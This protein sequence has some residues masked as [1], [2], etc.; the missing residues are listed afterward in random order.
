MIF[1]KERWR[2]LLFMIFLSVKR[3]SDM[4]KKRKQSDM[5]MDAGTPEMARHFNIVPRLS[6]PTTTTMKVLDGNEIDRL[7]LVDAIN[8]SQHATL[9]TLANKLLACGFSALRSP[10][11]SSPI[12]SDPSV[13]ADKKANTIRGAVSIIKRMDNHSL[14]GKYRRKQTVNLV[15]QDAPWKGQM[16]ELHAIIR[17]LEEILIG[18]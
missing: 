10:D 6:S 18:R 7:L 13:V 17:A 12:F 4:A 16:E 11:Y 5:G 3:G 1:R 8:P 9:T 15:I 14:I 2:A